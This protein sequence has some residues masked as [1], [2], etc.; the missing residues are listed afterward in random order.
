MKT[1]L[2]SAFTKVFVEGEVVNKEGAIVFA[3]FFVPVM[4]VITILGGIK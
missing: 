1:T 4:I 3:L 2:K